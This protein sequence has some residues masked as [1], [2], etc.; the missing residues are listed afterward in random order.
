MSSD[1]ASEAFLRESQNILLVFSDGADEALLTRFYGQVFRLNSLSDSLPPLAQKSV[2]LW[3]EPAVLRVKAAELERAA[4]ERV[5]VIQAQAE[6]LSEELPWPRLTLGQ[7]PLSVYGLGVYF[8]GFFDPAIDYFR[9]ISQEHSFQSLTESNKPG[10]A[11]RTGIYLTPVEKSGEELHFRLLRCSTNLAGPSENFQAHDW[12]IVDALNQQAALLFEN[13]APLNHVL[14]QIYPNLPASAAAKQTKARI[15]AHADKTK[16]MPSNGI[17]AFCTFYTGLQKLQPLPQDPFDHGHK[18]TSGLTRL[19]FR[20]KAPLPEL[21][22]QADLLP[23]QFS[24]TLYPHSLFLMPLSTNRL[25]THAIQSS[26]LNAEQLPTRMGYVVRCSATEAVHSQ[27]QT[28]LK[29]N[30]LR[31]PLAPPT[32][33]GMQALRRLYAEENKS[34]AAIHYGNQFNFSMNQGD[35][36]APLCQASDAFQVFTLPVADNLFAE[37][38]AGVPFEAV[39]KGRQGAVLVRPTPNGEVPIV[40]TTTAYRNPAQLFQA[41]HLQLAAQI[42]AWLEQKFGLTQRFNNA[43]IECYSNAYTRMGSHSDQALDLA[44]GSLIALFSCY[45]YPERALPPRK[46]IVE[47]KAEGGGSFEIPLTPNSVVVFSV[48]SNR[49][50]KHRIELQK[51]PST[52]DNQ[53]LGLTLRTSKTFVHFSAEQACLPDGSPLTLA[54]DEQRQAFLQMRRREN[55]ESDFCYPLLGF[56]LSESDR[57]PPLDT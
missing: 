32:P 44:E 23:E 4:A 12:Q 20:R 21:A 50:F 41:V 49:R 5:F 16:D 13:A 8:R 24:L 40:R 3:G 51:T 31:L 57:L 53:W 36:L 27:G 45:Q 48:D 26:M 33:E 52:P 29:R 28:Y 9:Q 18:Q 11:H 1:Q 47:A 46:L 39:G 22:D 10:K 25:Y 19:H 7:V 56:T 35:Y 42:Q 43:L 34:Q 55:Q 15:S 30:G 14:A 2:Y 37:L 17:M 38:Q 6:R 54:T